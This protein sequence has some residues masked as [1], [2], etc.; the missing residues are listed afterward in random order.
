MKIAH[1]IPTYFPA[2]R[3]GG[4]IHA[5]HDLCK[6]LTTRG[7]E[8]DVFTTNVDGDNSIGPAGSEVTYIDGVGV[9][10]FPVS[11]P[12]RLYYSPR[13][14]AALDSRVK[15]YDL[16]HLHS[17]FLYPTLKA[18]RCA[19]KNRIPYIVAP[20]GMLIKEM[21]RRR[22]SIVKNA[23]IA[24]FERRTVEQASAVHVTSALEADEIRKFRFALPPIREIPNGIKFPSSDFDTKREPNTLLFLGRIDWKKGIERLLSALVDLDG[25]RLIVAGNDESGYI[26]KLRSLSERLGVRGR[27]S[28]VGPVAG[29][30][31]WRLFR[32]AS[33]FVLPSYSEN[34]ANTVLEA[35]A[36]ECPVIVTPEVG[37][38]H[39]VSSSGAGV[40]TAGESASLAT[41]IRRVLEDPEMA[42]TMG[43]KGKA[44][45]E[46]EFSWTKITVAMESAYHEVVEEHRRQSFA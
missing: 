24:L 9:Q 13:L 1:I 15:E 40:V 43:Q 45:V 20:R 16:L 32:R 27:V 44:I 3:Y 36:M 42:L 41:A 11:R 22:N 39:T 46:D 28:F 12:R 34:F 6:N 37:L 18:A 23:W 25:T 26:Q 21:V 4:P 2:V 14:A 5:V 19:F 17:A 35:M 38:A 8:V 7:H 33:A 10:Y 29:E 31:K 30:E